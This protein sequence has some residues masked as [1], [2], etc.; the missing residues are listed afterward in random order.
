MIRCCVAAS[1]LLAAWL[2]AQEPYPSLRL[3]G[4][5][6][7]TT[8]HLVDSSA[9]IV[10]PWN[11]SFRPGLSVYMDAD[12]TLLRTID[13]GNP[14]VPGG[15]GGGL[16]RLAFDGTVL[17]DYRNSGN[18]VWSHHD[19]EPLPNGNVVM[20]AWEKK[21][22]QVAIAAGRNPALIQGEL[23]PDHL[24]EV[25]PTGPMSGEIVWEWHLFDH[26]I[27][28][29]DPTKH[30]FGVVSDHPELV[31][32]NYPPVLLT[33]GDWNHCNAVDYDP[34]HDWL[35]ISSKNNSEIWIIDH[36]TT[37][38]EAAGH[39]G[40]NYE[41]G[42]D[43]IYRWGNPA[44]YGRGTAAVQALFG[45]HSANF[46][47]EGY[48]G[49]G[50]I[51][52][53]NNELPGGSEAQEIVLPLNG[54]GRFV[55]KRRQAYGPEA[56]VWSY[57]LGVQASLVSSAR[58]APNGNT[59]ICSGIPTG[60]MVEVTAGGQPVWFHNAPGPVFHAHYVE[61]S[62]WAN[63]STLSLQ[64]GGTVVFDQ[65]A[66]SA[67]GGDAYLVLGSASG[68]SPGV[69]LQAK[70]LPL[71]PDGYFNAMLTQPNSGPFEATFGVLDTFGRGRASLML[72]AGLTVLEGWHLDH[73]FFAFD[74]KTLNV[75]WASNAVPLDL[76]R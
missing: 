45:Q 28:D 62:L 66:G 44:A 14:G 32:I 68:T 17:W 1:W 24:I 56:P 52:L 2:P 15:G 20:I 60:R 38:A 11:S 4:D 31:D 74:R 6:F 54:S 72:P 8:T 26:L 40:G 58:R 12:G 39:T 49:A 34:V 65:I 48:P 57:G 18:G 3:Y 51:L 37:T 23:W 33:T 21:T 36:S 42:G 7:G 41:M 71:N 25:K 43:I 35:V 75:S 63:R 22:H 76:I 61:T 47:P 13:V 69:S 67:R 19:I 53:Y 55:L 27:Q 59:L 30:N 50:N 73:A 29:F 10:H 16:Q 70:L 64:P 46:I 5:M 9:R